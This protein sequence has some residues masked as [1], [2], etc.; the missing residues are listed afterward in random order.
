MPAGDRL[1]PKTEKPAF[2]ARTVDWA[3]LMG[4]VNVAHGSDVDPRTA[5][6]TAV[7]LGA[8]ELGLSGWAGSAVKLRSDRASAGAESSAAELVRAAVQPEDM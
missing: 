4:S 2:G 8:V 6:P 1:T 7:E 5:P 3:L